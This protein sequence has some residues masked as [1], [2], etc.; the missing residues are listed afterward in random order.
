[1]SKTEQ[2]EIDTKVSSKLT[3]DVKKLEEVS[4]TQSRKRKFLSELEVKCHKVLG[5]TSVVI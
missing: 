4:S 5:S 1:M 2:S 3:V